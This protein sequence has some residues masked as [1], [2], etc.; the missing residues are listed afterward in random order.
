MVGGGGGGGGGGPLGQAER[1]RGGGV[2][3]MVDK[4]TD[5]GHSLTLMRDRTSSVPE[6]P[7]A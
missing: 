5:A 4:L 1:G 6:E 3:E 7:A 2:M